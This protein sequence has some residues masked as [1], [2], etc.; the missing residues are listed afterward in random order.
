MS[1]RHHV[2]ERDGDTG[3]LQPKTGGN[4]DTSDSQSFYDV[5][6]GGSLLLDHI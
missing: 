3:C 5:E 2:Y 6:S 1:T 4:G